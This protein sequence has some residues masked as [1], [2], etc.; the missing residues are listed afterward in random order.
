MA[1]E[2]WLCLL[3]TFDIDLGVCVREWSERHVLH[4]VQ[5]YELHECDERD[6]PETVRMFHNV[7]NQTKQTNV[8][9]RRHCSTRCPYVCYMHSNITW[10]LGICCAVRSSP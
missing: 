3:T 1:Y 5:C 8:T 9:I 6:R 10:F 7:L 2:S 4:Q